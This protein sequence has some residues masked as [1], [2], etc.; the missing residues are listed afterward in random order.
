MSNSLD[1]G[2]LAEVEYPGAF[3]RYQNPALLNYVA[4]AA[5]YAPRPLHP[6]F[7]YLE[8]GCGK[9]VTANVMAAASPQGEF[10]GV[11]A[12]AEHIADA[13]RQAEESGLT[14]ITFVERAFADLAGGE[15]P[16]FDF[17]T[18]HGV[19]A[20]VSEPVRREIRAILAAKLKP[21]GI[22][23]VMYG[24]K[25]GRAAVEPLRRLLVDLVGRHQGDLGARVEAGL[26]YLAR[27]RDNEA[28][29]F[30]QNPAAAEALT[31]A[32]DSS[33]EVAIHQFLNDSWEP[34]YFV[35]VARDMAESGLVFAGQAATARND[36]DLMLPEELKSLVR[37]LDDPLQM[38]QAKDFALNTGLRV[39]VYVRAQGP[40][41]EAARSALFDGLIFGTAKSPK[42][43]ER[44][45]QFPPGRLALSGK[46]YDEIL[47]CCSVVAHGMSE[48][49]AL[50]TLRDYTPAQQLD[51]LHYLV[52]AEQL[53]PFAAP[54]RFGASSAPGGTGPQFAVDGGYNRRVI[55][56]LRG[57][58]SDILLASPGLG[59]G[60]ELDLLAATVLQTLTAV[61]TERAP[62]RLWESLVSYGLGERIPG[63]PTGAPKDQVPFT[64][65]FLA[66]FMEDRLVKLLDLGVLGF[67]DPS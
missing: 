22:A 6:G 27:L 37:E 29:Y 21:G 60:I 59:T 39:D 30:V 33:V 66:D 10:W 35:D 14:N 15:L 42:S 8:L 49:R 41:P 61:G 24:A 48:I 3:C 2:Y 38:E 20:W 58:Q 19:Y 9:G 25:P 4:A 18:L 32:M 34:H 65:K 63:W 46:P 28:Q 40:V 5:G 26:R 54:S 51:A 17:V 57:D 47:A 13:R 43:I 56:G 52:S 62:G 45:V 67:A 64:A 44:E 1:A 23:Y 31:G 12:S 55:E 11:G 7:R 16:E 53:V 50:S 36:L